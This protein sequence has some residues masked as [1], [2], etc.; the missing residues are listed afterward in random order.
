MQQANFDVED[1]D[2]RNRHAGDENLFVRFYSLPVQDKEESEK[3]GRPIFKDQIMCGI[4]V[5]GTQ[6][7]NSYKA[8]SRYRNRFPRHY[9][10]YQDR[11]EMPE[12][13][14]PLSEWGLI[15]LTAVHEMAY[16]NIKTVEQLSE[17]PDS[18]LNFQGAVGYKSKAQK[19]LEEVNLSATAA[20]MKKELGE[21]DNVI[22]AMQ[23]ELQNLRETI[24]LASKGDGPEENSNSAPKSKRRKNALTED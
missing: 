5:P 11:V 14:T 15:P 3:A 4:R 12:I 19:W 24:S 20:D 9:K 22:A 18:K 13:G 8:T 23:E 7:E 17:L 6:H 10:A 21:R 1:F 2:N 16:L